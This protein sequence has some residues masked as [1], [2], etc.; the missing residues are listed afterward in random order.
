MQERVAGVAVKAAVAEVGQKV[1]FDRVVLSGEDA[2]VGVEIYQDLVE[3]SSGLED[4]S[5][6]VVEGHMAGNLGPD[7]SCQEVV[8]ILFQ[9]VQVED[10]SSHHILAAGSWEEV[11]MEIRLELKEDP[12]LVLD[13]DSA[14]LDLGGLN[15]A[16]QL[17]SDCCKTIGQKR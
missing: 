15:S 6:L 1:F 14:E 9:T 11:E 16:H 5:I 2:V 13:L 8:H 7:Q 17:I 10:H 3:G 12:A 4:H